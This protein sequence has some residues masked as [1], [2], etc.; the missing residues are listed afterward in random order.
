MLNFTFIKHLRLT[1]LSTLELRN[2]I[3]WKPK[4]STLQLV[5]KELECLLKLEQSKDQSSPNWNCMEEGK[6]LDV[7]ESKAME[8]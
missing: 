7:T 5:P 8:I 1:M 2:R 3:S 6:C 4:Y